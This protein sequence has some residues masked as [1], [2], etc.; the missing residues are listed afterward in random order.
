MIVGCAIELSATLPVAAIVKGPLL[1]SGMLLTWGFRHLYSRI[2]LR[3]SRLLRDLSIGV[4]LSI[5]SALA[6]TYGYN[7]YLRFGVS[8]V[9]SLLVGNPY[10]IR[11]NGPWWDD[12]VTHA[13][14]LLTWS[15]L[16]VGI[17][18]YRDLEQERERTLSAQG[19]MHLAQLRALRYQLQPHFL[20]NTLNA[21]STLVVEQRSREAVAMIA[22]LSDFLRMT[23][24]EGGS[25]EIP[26][27]EEIRFVQRYLEI[28]QVRFGD[29]LRVEFD[30][31]ETTLG[32][33]VPILVLQPLVENAVRHAVSA[34]TEGGAIRVEARLE[35]SCLSLSVTDDGPQVSAARGQATDGIGF[36]NTRERLHRLY[37]ERQSFTAGERPGGGFRVAIML[38]DPASSG[39]RGA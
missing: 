1:I 2:F 32:L 11:W 22:R 8:E 25:A 14:V 12:S 26:L 18:Y 21:I 36:A 17:R 28:E 30:I 19:Q 4:L 15:A 23:L 7:A 35:R 31:D 27:R 37:G 5:A 3:S 39:A 13:A 16:Y 24:D 38:P 10:H 33:S 20:F 9:A 34:R 29:R 6:W